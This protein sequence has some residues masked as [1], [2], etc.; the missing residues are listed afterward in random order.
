MTKF[1]TAF[2]L[3]TMACGTSE[4]PALSQLEDEVCG[5]APQVT[6][7][8]SGLTNPRGL[9]FGPDG[10]LYFT[11]AGTGGTLT[12]TNTPDC[13]ANINIYSPYTAGYSGRVSRI[14]R[15]GT[16][17]VVA[18][19]LPSMT[20]AFGGSYGATD[21]AFIGDTLY[22]LI[23]L[24]GC[25]HGM[26][27]NLPAV[28]RVN[29]DGTTTNVA[30][31]NAFI[32]ANPPF[33]L[34]DTNPATTDIEPGGVTHSMIAHDGFLYVVETNRGELL[35]VNPKNG[36]IKRLYD[37]SVDSREHNPIVMTRKGNKFY[38]GTF[39]DEGGPAELARFDKQ[40]SGYDLPFAGPI[41]PIVGL[42]WRGNTLYGVE[43]FDYD[44]QWVPDTGNLIK[45]DSDGN[46]ETVLSD[47]ASFPNGLIT[48]PD[49][50]LYTSNWGITYTG[51]GDGGI[52][53]IRL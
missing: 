22:V 37:M 10:L 31:L 49:G 36:E 27:D 29:K 53:R 38:V 51:A 47:F 48:G 9:I 3:L 11:E 34:P 40:F 26:P 32:T 39:G 17:Q 33:W 41:N 14:R 13:P 30:N 18:D 42:A 23:E 25:T 5:D 24:G 21:V 50:A 45:F 7:I 52:L 1:V 8:A 28:L 2:A 16:V 35:R 6:T 20:D 46:H 15:N 19:N 4:D 43:I 44:N 12:A